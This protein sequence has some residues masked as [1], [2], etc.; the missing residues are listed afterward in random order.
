MVASHQE[1]TGMGFGSARA[2]AE[3][4]PPPASGGET[5]MAQGAQRGKALPFKREGQKVG[6]NDPCPCGSGKKYKKCHG[7]GEG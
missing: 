7:A 6:R 2:A 4:A 1:S 5:V 3:D